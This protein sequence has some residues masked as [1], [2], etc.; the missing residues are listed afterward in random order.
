M[1]ACAHLLDLLVVLANPGTN[2]LTLVPGRIVPNQKP[3][4]LALRKQTLAAPVQEL[5]GDGTYRSSADKTQ[6]HLLAL[7]FLWSSLLPQDAIARQRFWVRVSFFPR[8]FD[9]MNR[10]LRVL[11]RIQTR[12]S[13][14][15]PPHLVLEADGPGRLLAGPS[16]QPV[17]CVFFPSGQSLRREKW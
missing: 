14:A 17:A 16:N 11:P 8:L 4:G 9:Q 10:M 2:R 7:W 15:A 5:R 3:V 13:K 1:Y 12:Q 6:P